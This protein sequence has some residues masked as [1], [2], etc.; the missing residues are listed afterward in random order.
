MNSRTLLAYVTAGGATEKYARVI[1]DA[2]RAHGHEVD[3]VDLKRERIRDLAAYE[4]IVVGAGVRMTMVYRR[5]KQFLARRDLKGKRLAVYLSSA[6]AIDEP[7]KARDKFLAPLIRR[8]GLSPVMCDAF[9]GNVPTAP[10][11]LEDRTDAD[12]A[13]RWAEELAGR[14]RDGA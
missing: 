7:D 13:R 11:K 14:L 12:V 10:G 1:A 8:H 4:N 5:G 2:L 9:P 6:M 3:L